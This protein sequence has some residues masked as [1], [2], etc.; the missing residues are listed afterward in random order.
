MRVLAAGGQQAAQKDTATRGASP[1]KL[2]FLNDTQE[3]ALFIFK[4]NNQYTERVSLCGPGRPQSRNHLPLLKLK[5]CA[6]LPMPAPR[7]PQASHLATLPF[8]TVK[9]SYHVAL[10]TLRGGGV[11]PLWSRFYFYFKWVLGIK[12]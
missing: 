1:H 12:L 3:A 8:G 11:G 4:E 7:F 5:T 9:D 10:C 6:I 2:H